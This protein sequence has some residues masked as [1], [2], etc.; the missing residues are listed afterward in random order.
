M[1]FMA[2]LGRI[3]IT[4]AAGQKRLDTDEDLFHIVT[5]LPEGV[6]NIPQINAPTSAQLNQ[7]NDFLLGSCHPAC[8]HVIGAVKF[9]ASQQFGAAFARWTTYMG[10]DLVWVMSAPTW[11]AG[12]AGD[13]GAAP[14][15]V[16]TYRFFAS[17]G[18]IYMRQR[19]LLPKVPATTPG[20]PS[21]QLPRILAHSV[22]YR[23]KAG[24]WT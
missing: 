20:V 17:G 14:T 6:R 16:C 11:S 8:T 19:L 9:S 4:N 5:T 21:N 3:L 7:N 2:R 10:G 23:L 1:S 12:G 15:F 24:L 13:I 22:T 18:G